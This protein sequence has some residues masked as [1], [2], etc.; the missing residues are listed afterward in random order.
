MRFKIDKYRTISF[1]T[2]RTLPTNEPFALTTQVEQV[3]YVDDNN[4]EG[5]IILVRARPH[6]YYNM[7]DEHLEDDVRDDEEPFQDNMIDVLIIGERINV[8]IYE[9]INI[10]VGEY[11]DS[12]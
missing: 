10:R 11:I 7:Q 6:D 5:W 4:A 12:D 3:F 1:N 8:D 2:R 9:R